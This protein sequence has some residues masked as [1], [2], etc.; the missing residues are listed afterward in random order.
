MPVLTSAIGAELD[1]VDTEMT[2]RKALAYAAGIADTSDAVFDDARDDGIIVPPAFCVSP[3]WP[4][5]S[6]PKYMAAMGMSLEERRRGVHYI[7]DSEFHRPLRPGL[8]LRTEGSVVAIR[9]SRA[10]AL[11]TSRLTTV[12]RDSGD[13]LVTSWTSSIVRGVEVEGED[14]ISETAP[15]L[16]QGSGE[17]MKEIE[18]FIPREMPHS[19]T[20][21]ADIWNP[22]HT[23]RQ[24]ALAA[25]LPDI[26]LHGTATWALAGR[27]VI[28]NCCAGAPGRLK[29]LHGRFTAMVIPGTSIRVVLEEPADGVV[30]FS[31]FN[32]D[33]AA[34]LSNGVAVVD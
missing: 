23:E 16:P 17:V 15:A 22:I 4:V 28:A 12:D 8:N 25:G 6:G 14:T 18:I 9:R 20:E 3:E 7:Q 1:V 31:V 29:R 21:C 5:V 32:A 13:L 34:A 2:A 24:V 19:Y 27:E 30:G 11:T 10:G 33:G 26:I